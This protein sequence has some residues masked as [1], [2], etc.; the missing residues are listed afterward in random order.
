MKRPEWLYGWEVEVKTKKMSY[1]LPSST[2]H[3][4]ILWDGHC[5]TGG[6]RQG[7]GRPDSCLR[8]M[9]PSCDPCKALDMQ[10]CDSSAANLISAGL[11][12][13]ESILNRL[14]RGAGCPAGQWPAPACPVSSA[15]FCGPSLAG[16]A[17]WG[18]HS[19]RL[20]P[21]PPQHLCDAGIRPPSMVPEAL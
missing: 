8:P 20:H 17:D 13:P 15:L 14:P 4:Q 12:G 5:E 9:L 21:G 16:S 7:W 18:L 11:P 19:L 6:D 3:V 2:H 1:H 10:S